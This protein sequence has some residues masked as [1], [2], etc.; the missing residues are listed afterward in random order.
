MT[1]G[2]VSESLREPVPFCILILELYEYFA[3]SECL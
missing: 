2:R 1:E 3:Y